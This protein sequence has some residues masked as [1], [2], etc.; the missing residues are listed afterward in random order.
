MLCQTLQ[1]DHYSDETSQ[2]HTSDIYQKNGGN[3]LPCV[4]S[5]GS[6]NMGLVQTEEYLP[7]SRTLAWEGQCDSGSGIKIDERLLRLDAQP[8][9][10]YSD[11]SINGPIGNRPVC[12]KTDKET[13]E[14]LQLESRPQNLGNRCIQP[15]LISLEGHANPHGA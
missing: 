9:N 6:N 8:T 10:L 2:C 3:S 15:E 14:V 11:K 1:Q 4:V 5:V 7:S 12:N 13:V